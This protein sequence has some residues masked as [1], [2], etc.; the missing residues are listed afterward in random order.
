MAIEKNTDGPIKNGGAATLS[1]SIPL[2]PNVRAEELSNWTPHEHSTET[3]FEY[4]LEI[5]SADEEVS[6]SLDGVKKLEFQ[7]RTDADLRWG[8]TSGNPA[9]S[10]DPYWTL[11]NDKVYYMEY[12][13]IRDKYIYFS[14]DT[15]GIVEVRTIK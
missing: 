3:I 12:G 9:N 14:S 7:F 1:Y 11:K 5:A 10:T 15:S 13:E 2:Y 4:N 6:L 8:H